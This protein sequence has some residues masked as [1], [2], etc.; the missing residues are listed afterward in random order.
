MSPR[1]T[2]ENELKQ[3]KENVTEM[4]KRVEENYESLLSGICVW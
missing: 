2:F 1:T 3:L 4:A